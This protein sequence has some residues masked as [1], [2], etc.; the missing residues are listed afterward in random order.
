MWFLLPRHMEEKTKNLPWVFPSPCRTRGPELGPFPQQLLSFCRGFSQ[1]VRGAPFPPLRTRRSK[2]RRQWVSTP[3]RQLASFRGLAQG[4][5]PPLVWQPR[6]TTKI[7]PLAGPR[8]PELRGLRV[9]PP[10]CQS[11]SQS[12]SSHWSRVADKRQP[13]RNK[14]WTWWWQEAPLQPHR[15]A[16]ALH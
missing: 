2:D 15:R 14:S 12:W 3:G 1:S 7:S 16:A 11:H 10:G 4:W 13:D 5:F 6:Q 9:P 8:L